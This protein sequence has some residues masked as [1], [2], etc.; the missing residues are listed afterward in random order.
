MTP[1]PG[2][3]FSDVE[4]VLNDYI[5]AIFVG[6]PDALLG[7]LDPPASK[8]DS[9]CSRRFSREIAGR[10]VVCRCKN[11]PGSIGLSGGGAVHATIFKYLIHIC[12]ALVGV[13]KKRNT[14]VI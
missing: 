12:N 14:Q 11:S 10:M 9:S 13:T 7:W 2:G 1:R 4:R 8:H 3:G 6:K 5:K